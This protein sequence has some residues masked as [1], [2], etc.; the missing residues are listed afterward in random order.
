VGLVAEVDAH[1]RRGV[2]LAEGR[3][4]AREGK[5]EEELHL[6]KEALLRSEKA[7]ARSR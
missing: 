2:S 5:D 4:L 6:K 7:Q 1:D 3:E